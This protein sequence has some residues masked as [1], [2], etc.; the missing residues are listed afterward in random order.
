[1]QG[2]TFCIMPPMLPTSNSLK[3]GC[4][5]TDAII[6]KVLWHIATCFT[7]F[8]HSQHSH[9]TS[10]RQLLLY[11]ITWRNEW[12]S[13]Q[14]HWSK[15]W[16]CVSSH[17]C[18]PFPLS[19]DQS[20]GSTLHPPCSSRR[21]NS[22]CHGS[23]RYLV[24]KKTTSLQVSDQTPILGCFGTPST[25]KDVFFSW[26]HTGRCRLYF[27]LRDKLYYVAFSRKTTV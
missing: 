11:C 8:R 27:S 7:N 20:G 25:H 3:S 6:S 1:M 4:P 22:I 13:D 9:T 19:S 21:T 12:P 17:L 5:L 23:D 16:W 18:V 10:C 14:P 26:T 24:R 2:L 15:S